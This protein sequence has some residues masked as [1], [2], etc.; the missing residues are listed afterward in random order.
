[1]DRPEARLS[2]PCRQISGRYQIQSFRDEWSCPIELSNPHQS[3]SCLEASGGY[4]ASWVQKDW[5][6][7]NLFVIKNDKWNNIPDYTQTEINGRGPCEPSQTSLYAHHSY[8]SIK[9]NP[10]NLLSQ[11]NPKANCLRQRPSEGNIC[12]SNMVEMEIMNKWEWK[13]MWIKVIQIAQ[14]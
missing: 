8:F 7:P 12:V 2:P 10:K 5:R 3:R 11:S 4:R 1:M 9:Q 6:D 14:T 13:A